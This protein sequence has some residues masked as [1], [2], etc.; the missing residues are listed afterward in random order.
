MTRSRS[1]L[2][3]PAASAAGSTPSRSP[4]VPESVAIIMDGNGR[5]AKA[6]G[7]PRLL[8]HRSGAKTV[9]RVTEYCAERGVRHLALYAFSTE[10]WRRPTEEVT[11]LWFLLLREIRRRESKLKK[12][13]I[14][15]RGLGRRDRMPPEVEKELA[16]VERSTLDGDRMTLYLCLDYGGQWDICA[17]A[18]EVRRRERAAEL[19]DRPLAP[20]D[21][22][23]LLPSGALPEVDLLIRTAGERRLSNFLPWQLAYSELHFT[24][25]LWPEFGEADLERAFLD[26]AGRERRYGASVPHKNGSSQ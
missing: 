16:R 19:P 14:R 20:D 2:L 10:N 17:L 1:S 7:W 25:V 6:R 5:W 12:N 26:F 22:A 18:D 21:I 9:D 23:R 15:L 3:T 24:D 8:G 4:V 11:G 13:R